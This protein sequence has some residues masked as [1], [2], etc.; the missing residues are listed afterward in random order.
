MALLFFFFPKLD[1]AKDEEKL[2]SKSRKIVQEQ[3]HADSDGTFLLTSL[4][5]LQF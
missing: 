5:C 4:I 1:S 2:A 3:E